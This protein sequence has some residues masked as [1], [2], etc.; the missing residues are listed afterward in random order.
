MVTVTVVTGRDRDR[1]KLVTPDTILHS[2]SHAHSTLTQYVRSSPKS[3]SPKAFFGHG[4]R[5]KCEGALV[6][7]LVVCA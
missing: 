3:A 2:P 7:H 1:K 4:E 5:P 6:E